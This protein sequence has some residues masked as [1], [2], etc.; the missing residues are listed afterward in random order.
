MSVENVS[1][2]LFITGFTE[3]G[4]NVFRKITENLAVVVSTS[5]E[6]SMR[7]YLDITISAETHCV[8]VSNGRVR[9]LPKRANYLLLLN[10]PI[11]RVGV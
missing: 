10:R 8:V 11:Y 9:S 5:G 7:N 1:R 3:R 2:T 6:N 4:M